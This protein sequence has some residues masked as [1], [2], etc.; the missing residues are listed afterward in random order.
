MKIRQ[1]L[2]TALKVIVNASWCT[3]LERWEFAAYVEEPITPG[4]KCRV[5]PSADDRVI[6]WCGAIRRALLDGD[7]QISATTL[8]LYRYIDDVLIDA[9]DGPDALIKFIKESF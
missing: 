1:A 8:L 6:E 5:S 3:Y 7:V 9:F 4:G 2:H